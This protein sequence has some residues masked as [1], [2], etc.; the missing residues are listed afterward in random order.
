MA[1]KDISKVLYNGS[2]KIDYKDKAHRYYV[3]HRLN[4]D[5]NPDNPKAWSKIV[6]PMGTTTLIGDTLEKKGLMTWPMGLALGEL[7]GFYDF[8]TNDGEQKTGFTKNKGTLWGDGHLLHVDKD[9]ALPLIL[10]AS[11]AWQRK[12]AKGADI[13]SVVH[14]AIEHYVLANPNVLEPVVDDNGEPVIDA[15]GQ[16]KTVMPAPGRPSH[17]DIKEQYMW[18][19][20]EAITDVE[21][22]EFARAMD[23]FDHDTDCAQKA[24]DEFKKWWDTTRPALYGAEDLLYS[25]EYNVSGTYDGDIG[26]PV[27]FHPRAD[28][29]PNKEFVRCT[30]DWKTSNA[31]S[32]KD[33][34]A[35]EG[36][37]Y[38]Y[39]IQLAIYELMRREMGMP[40]ADDLL[41]VSAR[42]DGGFSLVYASELGLT[43]DECLE[44]AKCVITCAVLAKKTKKALLEHAEPKEG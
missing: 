40:P 5:M 44:W 37:Y 17:F 21:S 23:D 14:D 34:A 18:N 15:N 7:F 3:R 22:P 9:T 43:V 41:T 19:I 42:K 28:L 26:I 36:V 39:F 33:A 25:K 29:F 2:I 38:S 27:M 35:P 30:T 4:Y 12:Q 20:K 32:S 6:Y 13:G 31:S 24:F 8:K 1:F 10:S 11:K 16:P